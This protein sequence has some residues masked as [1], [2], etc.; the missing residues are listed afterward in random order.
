MTAIPVDPLFLFAIASKGSA[1]SGRLWPE[2][3]ALRN[4]ATVFQQ[5]H[6][7]LGHFWLQLWDSVLITVAVAVAVAAITLFVAISATFA[8]GRRKVRGGRTVMNLALF[9]GFL[10]AAFLAVPMHEQ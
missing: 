3:P 6:F 10:P 4:F 1:N 5:R 8:D 7:F 2:E 9:T